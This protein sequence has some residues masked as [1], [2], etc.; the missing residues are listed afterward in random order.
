M[1][2]K[3]VAQGVGAAGLGDAS[4]LACRL[5]GALN[6]FY[7]GGTIEL[8]VREQPMIGVLAAVVQAMGAAV[9]A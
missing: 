6:V 7:G 8:F 2:S 4:A 1:G 9:A 3:A 5:V